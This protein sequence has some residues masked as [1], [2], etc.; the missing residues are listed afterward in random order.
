[1]RIFL[2]H[3]SNDATVVRGVYE[4]LGAGIAWLDHAEIEWGDQ[5]LAKVSEGLNE[6]TD[7]MLFWS[8]N[9]AKSRWVE[10]E[11]NAA[12]IRM[13]N[14][15]GVSL[16]IIRLDGTELPFHLRVYQYVD[17]STS[18]DPVSEIVEAVQ[19][20]SNVD[21]GIQRNRFVNRSRELSRLETAVDTPEIFATIIGG[22]AGIGKSSLALEG[23]R[24]FYRTPEIVH[25]EVRAGTGLTELALY[26]S[27]LARA[28]SMPEGL[29]ADELKLDLRLSL[30]EIVRTGR[31]LVLS[32]IQHWLDEDG[33]PTEPLTT[34]LGTLESTPGFRR[35]P[36]LMTSTRRISAQTIRNPGIA[37]IW[38]EGLPI[39]HVASLVRL[40]YEI[41]AGKELDLDDA[42][43]VANQIH[44]HP[45]AAQLAA[46]LVS[47]Y[48]VEYL[49]Q[50][51]GEYV[52]LRRDFGSI[53]V[54]GRIAR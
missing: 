4:R 15:E 45:I 53:Y 54:G 42:T 24:R 11:L 25:I 38:L 14:N 16:R 7:F 5:F 33:M 3:S 41:D 29:S 9:S 20:L 26:L 17:V 30:E 35:S 52:S 18:A 32:N 10:F 46:S 31:F 23:L 39:E 22:F 8:A 13:M 49:Q 43:L 28:Q 40:W 48:G 1:M 12:F 50:D 36:C 34:V 21:R 37:T 6:A 51:A 2:S 19:R 47:Q 27:S 44:G